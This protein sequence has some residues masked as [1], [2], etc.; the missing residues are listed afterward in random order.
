L[1]IIR[2]YQKA[3]LSPN[4]IINYRHLLDNFEELFGERELRTISSEEIFY[5]VELLTDNASTVTK[6]H[7]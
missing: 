3:N 7:R 5:F 1:K 6:N 2:D 4:T